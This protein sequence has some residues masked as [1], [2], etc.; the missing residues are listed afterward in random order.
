MPHAAM[1]APS[2]GLFRLQGKGTS[3]VKNAGVQGSPNPA[4]PNIK[5]NAVLA[6]S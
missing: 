6:D 1:L 3:I 2:A 4:L 5:A